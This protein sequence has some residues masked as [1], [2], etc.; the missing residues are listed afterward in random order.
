MSRVVAV[1][2]SLLAATA[3]AGSEDRKKLPEVGDEA[4]VFALKD[5]DGKIVRLKDFRGRKNVVI[6]FY[7]KDFTG[8]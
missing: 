3:A 4:P 1:L 6:A 8:G 2:V 7:P 5:Q